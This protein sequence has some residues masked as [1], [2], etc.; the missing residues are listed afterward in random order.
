MCFKEKKIASN[1]LIL[2]LE[3]INSLLC[4]F[5][6]LVLQDNELSAVPL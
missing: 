4:H 5:I 3:L 2:G 6:F 1:S